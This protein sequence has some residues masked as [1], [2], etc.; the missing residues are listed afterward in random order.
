MSRSRHR[1]SASPHLSCPE[2]RE[3][4]GRQQRLNDQTSR[5]EPGYCVACV[6]VGDGF[7]SVRYRTFTLQRANNQSADGYLGKH[8]TKGTHHVQVC[9]GT[10]Y[11]R[12]G[13]GVPMPPKMENG[14]IIKQTEACGIS[15]DLKVKDIKET[16]LQKVA[17]YIEANFVTGDALRRQIREN[18]AAEVAINS[19]RGMHHMQLSRQPKAGMIRSPLFAKGAKR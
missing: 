11:C 1:S 3:P 5:Y 8:K 10:R 14:K 9:N 19:Q 18:V 12:K 6:I 16:Y 13:D 2:Q 17:S 7:R 4:A 15:K